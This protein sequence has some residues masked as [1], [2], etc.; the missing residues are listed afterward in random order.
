MDV[1]F[2]LQQLGFQHEVKFGKS[3]VLLSQCEKRLVHDGQSECCLDTGSIRSGDL[4]VDIR[5]LAGE[6]F[7]LIRFNGQCQIRGRIDDHNASVTHNF[8]TG[9]DLVSMQL[10]SSDEVSTQVDSYRTF[11]PGY[12]HR[13]GVHRLTLSDDV[14][15]NAAG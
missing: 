6:I 4:E 9:K 13:P 12:L 10:Q 15:I 7:T 1:V 14:H 5:S 2:R 3:R 8:A 11:P